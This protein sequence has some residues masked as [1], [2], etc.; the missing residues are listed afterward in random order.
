MKSD[1]IKSI[2][3]DIFLGN[4]DLVESDNFVLETRPLQVVRLCNHS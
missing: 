3:N 4:A 2:L 1:S